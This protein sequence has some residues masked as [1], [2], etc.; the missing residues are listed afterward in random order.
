MMLAWTLARDTQYPKAGFF[1]AQALR[2]S[3][4]DPTS[5]GVIA[6]TDAMLGAGAQ[7]VQLLRQSVQHV[8]TH[9]PTRALLA[10]LLVAVHQPAQALEVVAHAGRSCRPLGS[11]WRGSRGPGT[12]RRHGVRLRP[13]G[14]AHP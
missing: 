10:R 11:P 3:D 13:R 1:R 9:V 2:Y 7:A 8:P 5:V 12:H 6:Q 4:Q 14:A